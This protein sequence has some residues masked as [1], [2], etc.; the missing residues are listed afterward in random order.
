MPREN[1]AIVTGGDSSE[2]EVSL[3]TCDYV[4]RTL[5]Q[6]NIDCSTFI[7]SSYK[8]FI[9]LPFSDFTRVFL[10]LHGGFG[11]NGMA[12]AYLRGLGIPHNGP[13]PQASAICMDKLLTKHIA[14]GLGIKVPDYLFFP[15]DQPI[16]FEL[17]KRRFGSRFIV[18][19]NGGGCSIGVSLINDEAQFDQAVKLASS[20]QQGILLEEFISG[21]ELSV[22]Y[23]YGGMLPTLAVGFTT[24]FFSYE[25]KFESNETKSWFIE[26]TEPLQRKIDSD[27]VIF[28]KSLGL[29]YYR[30]DV[31]INNETPYLIEINTLPGL[32]SHSLFPKACARNN[33]APQELI[34]KLNN[35]NFCTTICPHTGS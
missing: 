28:A 3:E 30:A 25:A 13:S 22:S 35:L 33:I 4:S 12:Q 32:T 27:G 18:K 6:M 5:H 20:Y 9:A 16:S 19:P 23:F 15:N 31:I 2:R 21:Q 29:D 34:S 1:I 7:I 17:A 8:D 26:L 10:A 14:K 11:E 24:D